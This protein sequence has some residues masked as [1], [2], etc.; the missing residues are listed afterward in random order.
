MSLWR[1]PTTSLQRGE[2]FP[3][4]IS[5][6]DSKF[7]NS[8]ET[9]KQSKYTRPVLDAHWV[10]KSPQKGL[11][12]VLGTRRDVTLECRWKLIQQIHQTVCAWPKWILSATVTPLAQEEKNRRRDSK[13]ISIE[14]FPCPITRRTQQQGSESSHL[15]IWC[16]DEAREARSSWESG[17]PSSWVTRKI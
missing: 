10:T 7:Q 4:W 3:R 12:Q 15:R 1:S 17:N 6:W 13:S 16:S 8:I 9:R 11:Y 5:T 14:W 2:N